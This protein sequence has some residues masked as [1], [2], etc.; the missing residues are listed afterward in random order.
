MLSVRA[1]YVSLAAYRACDLFELGGAW[2]TR[3]FRAVGSR[4]GFRLLGLRGFGSDFAG[5]V[6]VHHVCHNLP[7]KLAYLGHEMSGGIF[8]AFDSAQ[9]VFP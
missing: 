8:S 1:H 3:L 9:L 2:R 7:H 4:G 5:A 6:V